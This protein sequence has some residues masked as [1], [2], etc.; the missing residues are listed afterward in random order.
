MTTNDSALQ[1]RKLSS[2]KKGSCINRVLNFHFNAARLRKRE[3]KIRAICSVIVW[4]KK[5]KKKTR[6]IID[7]ISWI[8]KVRCEKKPER[9]K[10]YFKALDK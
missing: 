8:I 7:F 9:L 3:K 1:V 5:K 4:V 6:Y 10:K 2:L